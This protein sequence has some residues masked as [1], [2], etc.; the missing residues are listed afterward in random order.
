MPIVAMVLNR[1]ERWKGI[2]GLE[3][4]NSQYKKGGDESSSIHPPPRCFDNFFQQ[5]KIILGLLA[6]IERMPLEKGPACHFCASKG[7]VDLASNRFLELRIS[8]ELIIV[9]CWWWL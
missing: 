2:M 4:T 6:D 8:C 3:D 1:T 7:F 9:G 5:R